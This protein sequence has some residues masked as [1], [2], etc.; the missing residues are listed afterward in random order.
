MKNGQLHS[1]LAAAMLALGASG[2]A[3]AGTTYTYTY[4]YNLSVNGCGG[5]WYNSCGLSGSQTGSSVN[6][7]P[8]P[9]DPNA[10]SASISASAT[11]WANTQGNQWTASS[12]TLEKGQMQAWGGGIGVRN[13]DYSTSANGNE[14][15]LDSNEGSSP[16]HATDNEQRWDS[17]VYS[18]SQAISLTNVQ[19]SWY[20]GDADLTVL[21]YTGADAANAGFNIDSKLSG[22]RYD[23]LTA[24][25]WSFIQN[26]D[27]T[28]SDRYDQDIST[29]VSSSYWLIGAFNS[30]F[31]SGDSTAD[32]VKIAGLAGTVT[33]Q[34]TPP[35]PPP[36]NGA[37]PEPG[38]V[39][40]LGLGS[41]LLARARMKKAA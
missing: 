8:A 28:G 32:H 23:Q 14:S 27:Y 29:S 35:P 34:Y 12:Q 18:F 7:S 40:L 26:T 11:S 38:S 3:A 31:G 6:P 20:S 5:T 4:D 33:N 19:A 37:V 16:E 22:L 36:P 30:T 21:A 9:A 25:G 17:I 13:L 24:N 41:L 39:L 1:I 2:N 15:R 10:P